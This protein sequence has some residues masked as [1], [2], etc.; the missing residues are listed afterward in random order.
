M[1]K[2]GPISSNIE[3]K[4]FPK[5]CVLYV[6]VDIECW[7]DNYGRLWRDGAGYL[8]SPTWPSHYRLTT[9]CSIFQHSYLVFIFTEQ[10]LFLFK[11]RE[12]EKT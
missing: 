4:F 5:N 6:V 1:K 12:R 8:T 7:D 2:S 10:L 11:E 9:I 3:T